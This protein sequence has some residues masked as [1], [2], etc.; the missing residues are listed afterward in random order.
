MPASITIATG[1]MG[2][3]IIMRYARTDEFAMAP[4]EAGLSSHFVKSRIIAHMS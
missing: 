2:G 1:P 4:S 3:V